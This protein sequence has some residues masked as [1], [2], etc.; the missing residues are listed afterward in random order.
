MYKFQAAKSDLMDVTP[1][2]HL[3]AMTKPLKTSK[4]DYLLQQE[5]PASMVIKIHLCPMQQQ[6]QLEC[7]KEAMG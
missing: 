1:I 7:I 5:Q 2:G 6:A 3:L 4:W